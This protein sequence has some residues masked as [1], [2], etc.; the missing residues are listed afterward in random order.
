MSSLP[1]G[2]Y[3]KKRIRSPKGRERGPGTGSNPPGTGAGNG[4]KPYTINYRN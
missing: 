2:N 3:L 1:S 4:V